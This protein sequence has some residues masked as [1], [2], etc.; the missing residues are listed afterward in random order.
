MGTRIRIKRGTESQIT[1]YTGPHYEGELAFATNTGG[2]FVNDGTQF[3]SVGGSSETPTLQSVT[4]AG[5]TTTNSIGIGTATPGYPL[6]IVTSNNS[7][8][9]G[10]DAGSAARFRFAGNSTSGYTST[11]NIDDT[12]LDIGHDSTARSLNLKTGNQDRLT[13][14]GAGNVGIGTTAPAYKLDVN[15]DARIGNFL[16]FSSAGTYLRDSGS[17]ALVLASTSGYIETGWGARFRVRAQS[18]SDTIMLYGGGDSYIN[19][20]NLGIGTTTP[21]AKLHVDSGTDSISMRLKTN[22]V[23]NYILLNNSTSANNYL[24][25]NNRTIALSA[26]ENGVD[27]KVY[28]KTSNQ[29]RVTVNGIGNVGIG[30][31]TPGSLL[32]IKSNVDTN[33][34]IRLS[35]IYGYASIYSEGIGSTG[36]NLKFKVKADGGGHSTPLTI[37]DTGNVGIGTTAPAA[38]LDVVGDVKAGISGNGTVLDLFTNGVAYNPMSVTAGGTILRNSGSNPSLVA[39]KLRVYGSVVSI[40]TGSY[41]NVPLHVQGQAGNSTVLDVT[42][43]INSSLFRVNFD[44]N[45]GIGTTAPA[46][47]LHVAGEIRVN[48]GQPVMF[49]VANNIYAVAAQNQFRLYSGGNPAI[50]IT[51]AGRVGIGTTAPTE[52]LHITGGGAGNIRLDAGGTYYGTNIQAISSAGLKIGNDDFSGYAFFADDGN[53]GIGTTAPSYPFVVKRTGS[54]VVASF[55]GD[56]NTYL[57]IART[58]TQPGEAQLRVTNN[59]NFSITSDSNI[60]LKTGGISGTTRLYIRNTDGNVGIG[61]TAPIT[62]L[63]VKGTLA[64][65][66]YMTIE[67]TVHLAKLQ[68]K[69]SIYTGNLV[70]DGTGGYIS[71]GGLILDSGTNPRIQFLQSGASKMSIVSGNVGIGTT[72]PN[73]KVHI[74]GTAMQQLRMETAGGPSSSG[75]TSGRIGDMAYDDDFFYIKT[76]NGWG[77]VQLDFGF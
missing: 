41:L 25:A 5:N 34:E 71:G 14:L 53:V 26:D 67:N 27:G 20:G 3:I 55:E 7:T 75:D 69:S 58:G 33:R 62:A 50:S 19:G 2:V 24:Q 60:S 44:G 65:K 49:D 64:G 40:G 37:S 51:T 47:K 76:A 66:G 57:R 1:G 43:N 46:A 68:L 42:N 28:L 18:G 6:H 9:L 54:N 10:L 4:D 70:M 21:A 15:G 32:D 48:A 13:I 11:F 17:G 61:T 39:N 56:Q 36:S 74:S 22:N 77:R 31:T 16:R 63:H 12:G 30:T 29:N 45:V 8:V 73:S 59:G 35:A 52:K 72:A 38:K 23:L